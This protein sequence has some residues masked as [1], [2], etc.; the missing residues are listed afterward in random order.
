[1]WLL[2]YSWEWTHLLVSLLKLDQMKLENEQ[3]HGWRHKD[4]ERRWRYV[5]DGFSLY[6]EK[7]KE[8]E[9][10]EKNERN[11][12]AKR[13]EEI[14]SLFHLFFHLYMCPLLFYS[15]ISHDLPLLNIHIISFS[16]SS[17]FDGQS[18]FRTPKDQVP[19]TPPCLYPFF[20]FLF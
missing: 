19:H 11:D 13:N 12:P 20:S 18:S 9:Q 16:L 17:P 3:H 14:S 7:E 5:E 8:V 6:S 1:M 2:R 10:N 15:S 4:E